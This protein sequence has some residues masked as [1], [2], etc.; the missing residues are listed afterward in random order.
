MLK[1]FYLIIILI[2][3]YSNQSCTQGKNFCVLCEL[4]TDLCKKCES[5]LFVPDTQGGCEGAKKCKKDYNYCL[6]CPEVNYTCAKCEEGYTPDNNGGCA[7]VENCEVSEDGICKVC[8]ENYALIYKGHSYLECVSMD[9]EE[10]LN[11]EEYDIYGHCLKCKENYYMNSGDKK[12]SNTENCYN[13]TKGLCDTCD[14]DFYLDKSNKTDYLCL[15]NNEQNNFW[16]CV[17]SEDGTFCNKCL[18]PYFL[19]S[20]KICVESHFC[21]IGDIGIGKCSQCLDNYYLTED[22]YS[23]TISNACISGYNYNTKCRICKEG[24]YNDLKNGNCASNQ[25]DN[26]YKYCLTVLEKCESCID[27]YYLGKDKKCSNTTNCLESKNGI[28]EKCIEGYHPGKIDYKCINIDNCIKTNLNNYCEECDTGYFVYHDEKCVTE[29]IDK[30]HKNCKIVYISVEHCSVCKNGFYIDDSDYLC[31]SN[32]DIKNKFYKC[33]K[34]I[35]NSEGI[36]QCNSCESPYYLGG[37]NKCTLIPGCEQSQSSEV[38]SKCMSG[39]CKNNLLKTCQPNSYLDEDDNNQVCYRCLETDTSGKKCIKCDEGFSLS[40]E[41]FCIDENLCDK[42]EGEKCLQCKQNIKEEQSLKSYCLNEQYGCLESLEGCLKCNDF[43]NPQYCAQ[44]FS[45]FYLEEDFNFC[46]P[47][48]EGC[49]TCTNSENCGKC[50]EEGYYIKKEASSEEA[51]DAECGKCGEGCKICTNDLDCEI[52]FSG[53]FLN[54]KNK[55]NIMKCSQCS[56]WCEECFDE[57]Y[58]LKCMEGYHLV[59]SGDKVICE[60][61][62]DNSINK[63]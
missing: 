6:E 28:C 57:S 55:D 1:Y 26:D 31:Y 39:W 49:D 25:E 3:S 47:C 14:Y 23:C 48:L 60:Y 32:T 18:D 59:L 43:Y 44:C 11:C 10:L 42:K 40:K 62:Q 34:V 35:T 5:D 45:G 50:K 29:D 54:N 20:N 8:I 63:K 4:A 12:C 21:K 61:K 24:Y 7:N 9:S 33:S 41:G 36:K 2:F 51:F 13:S 30:N 22:K 52:C 19:A 46:Y 58:C 27:N 15:S 56:T 37:D 38:C 16:K 17:L 53:Y